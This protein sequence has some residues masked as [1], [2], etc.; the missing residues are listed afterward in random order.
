VWGTVGSLVL[1]AACAAGLWGVRRRGEETERLTTRV[2]GVLVAGT[3]LLPLVASLVSTAWATRYLAMA[4]GPALLL[5]GIALARAGRAGVA[6]TVALV[7]LGVAA[8][9]DAWPKSNAREVARAA[10]PLLAGGD[11]VASTQ[12]EQVPVLAYS[13]GDDLRYVTPLG[14]AADP[15]V[16]DWRNAL[17]LLRAGTARRRL[18]PELDALPV[19]GTVL[20]VVPEPWDGTRWARLVRRRSV[21][22]RGALLRDPRFRPLLRARIATTYGGWSTLRGYAFR[23]VARGPR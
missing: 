1:V 5:A 18:A 2:L 12:P 14:P 7:A 20:L 10:A 13:L 11:L 23:K 9:P 6:A 19:G 15:G 4:L 16:T 21:E 17:D 3:V 8:P 22:W